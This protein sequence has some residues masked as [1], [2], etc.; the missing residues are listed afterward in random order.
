MRRA[1]RRAPPA[2]ASRIVAQQRGGLELAVDLELGQ[3][4]ADLAAYRAERHAR[5]LSDDRRPL[6]LREQFEDLALPWRQAPQLDLLVLVRRLL[7]FV[8]HDPG[9][10]FGPRQNRS[11]V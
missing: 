2:A 10:A 7:L 1:R 3:D 8:Q 6:A 9:R 5:F 11:S 4:R